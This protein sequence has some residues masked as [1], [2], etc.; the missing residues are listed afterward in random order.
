MQPFQWRHPQ[1]TLYLGHVFQPWRPLPTLASSRTNP[2]T[3]GADPGSRG[4]STSGELVRT[5]WWGTHT[6]NKGWVLQFFSQGGGAGRVQFLVG[7][8]KRLKLHV[9]KRASHLVWRETRTLVTLTHASET[10]SLCLARFFIR[11]V[12][13]WKPVTN[14]N[15]IDRNAGLLMS[16]Y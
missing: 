12:C 13:L 16:I 15:T 6:S 7:I 5:P 2:T 4:S 11:C 1:P 9:S 14:T 10:L 3:G 8:V